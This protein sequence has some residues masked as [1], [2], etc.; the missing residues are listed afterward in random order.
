[1]RS[2]TPEPFMI[3][4]VPLTPEQRKMWEEFAKT[5]REWEEYVHRGSQIPQEHLFGGKRNNQ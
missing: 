5:I 2:K 1:M 3:E 4:P